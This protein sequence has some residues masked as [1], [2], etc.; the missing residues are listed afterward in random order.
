M[1]SLQGR[2]GTGS[3]RDCPAAPSRQFEGAAI[4]FPRRLHDSFTIEELSCPVVLAMDTTRVARTAY[5][6]GWHA[7]AHEARI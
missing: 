6:H 3:C 7:R 5:M 1:V 4:A 2:A